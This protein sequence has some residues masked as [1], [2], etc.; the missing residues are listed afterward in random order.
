MRR[1][2]LLGSGGVLLTGGCLRLEEIATQD[3][4]SAATGEETDEPSETAESDG[5]EDTEPPDANDS[6]TEEDGGDT[7]DSEAEEDD[8]EPPAVIGTWP[9]FG[10][11]A[12]N[13]GVISG[14][15]VT[16]KELQWTHNYGVGGEAGGPILADGKVIV[17]GVTALKPQTGDVL[18][19]S[20]FTGFRPTPAY[21]D[22]LVFAGNDSALAALNADTGEIA[23]HQSFE[24]YGVTVA[25]D[26]LYARGRDTVAA[27]D[28]S[29]MERWRAQTPGEY[30]A[31]HEPAVGDGLVCVTVFHTEGT[32][33]DGQLIAF[34]AESGAQQWVYEI[35]ATAKF[36]P[37]IAN[38]KVFFGGRN[39]T[40]HA[41]DAADGSLDWTHETDR[42]VETS[43]AVADG[44]VY[45]GNG[46]GQIVGAEVETGDRVYEATN[47]GIQR[48]KGGIAIADTVIYGVGDHGALTA[49]DLESG[50]LLWYHDM[51]R[52]SPQQQWPAPGDGYVFCADGTGTAY[53]F[54]SQ[55][56]DDAG[57]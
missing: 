29:G 2:T 46:S 45:A 22:G 3:T 51:T 7:N 40:I 1:R 55:P 49:N 21:A 32:P 39:S 27:F 53:A 16:E 17:N 12:A 57:R 10:N 54:G 14:A 34:D 36:A 6:E 35:G 56:G 20:P 4:N 23:W 30:R 43:P 5:S 50:E 28:F 44:V 33:G 26:L 8:S 13:T 19:E 52:V 15:G 24:T 11:D 18:W 42:W 41:V 37:T 9:Q 47:S 31:R 48:Y 25:D 38:G